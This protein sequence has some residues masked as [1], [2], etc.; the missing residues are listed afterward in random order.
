MTRKQKD[1]A[2]AAFRSRLGIIATSFFAPKGVSISRQAN[3][4]NPERP[5]WFRPGLLLVPL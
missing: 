2:K 3:R 5:G 4:F 1:R